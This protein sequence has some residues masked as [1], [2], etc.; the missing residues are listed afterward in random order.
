MKTKTF[1]FMYTL[2]ELVAFSQFVSNGE[3]IAVQLFNN[4]IINQNRSDENTQLSI[5][6]IPL[7]S[8]MKFD[9]DKLSINIPI[10]FNQIAS[11]KTDMK[12]QFMRSTIKKQM[13][14]LFLCNSSIDGIETELNALESGVQCDSGWYLFDKVRV[15][16]KHL[17]LS[18]FTKKSEYKLNQ[19]VEGYAYLCDQLDYQL[20]PMISG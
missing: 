5:I 20:V 9:S 7:T 18:A 14:G 3:A 15:K 1:L 11:N 19:K 4:S 6:P 16:I 17:P 2:I 10:V 12:C 13:R 8:T